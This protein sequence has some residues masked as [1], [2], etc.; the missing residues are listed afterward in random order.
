[1]F[2]AL[3]PQTRPEAI[4]AAASGSFVRASQDLAAAAFAASARRRAAR[5]IVRG[6]VD[7]AA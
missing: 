5:R 3:S 6:A 1:M 7:F 4:L 2:G